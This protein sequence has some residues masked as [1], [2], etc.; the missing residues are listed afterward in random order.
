MARD[1]SEE[2]SENVCPQVKLGNLTLVKEMPHSL[3]YL[4]CLGFYLPPESLVPPVHL[5]LLLDEAVVPTVSDLS[6][7]LAFLIFLRVEG[8]FSFLSSVTCPKL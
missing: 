1:L 3:S 6:F 2:I 8:L 7:S 4:V 5:L